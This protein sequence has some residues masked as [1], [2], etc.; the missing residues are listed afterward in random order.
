MSKRSIWTIIIIMTLSLVGVGVIQ[1]F[2]IMKAVAL[3][4]KNFNDKVTIA[5]NNVK[6]KM[7]SDA[8]TLAATQYYEGQGLQAPLDL[9]NES[10]VPGKKVDEQNQSIEQRLKDLEFR[11]ANMKP[12]DLLDNIDKD[13]LDKYLKAE[14]ETK[15]IDLHYEYGVYS[16]KYRSYFIENGSYTATIGDTTKSSNVAAMNPLSKAEFKIALFDDELTSPGH[17]QIYFPG[18]KRFI[19]SSVIGILLSSVVFTGLI[20]FCFA[21]TIYVI[22]HQKKVSEMKTDFINNMTHE[23]KTPIATISLASDSILS[24][25]ILENKEKVIR[26]INIIK[27]ENK[28]MLSQVEKVLQMAQIEKENVELKFNPMNL[29]EVIQDA[30]INAE[31]KVQTKGGHIAINLLAQKPV[32]QADVT[33]ISSIINNLLDNAEKYTPENPQITVSTADVKGGIEFSV[34][35]N[36]IGMSKDALKYIFEKFYRVH[37]GNLHDVKGFGLG[38]SYV[39][40]MVDAHKGKVAVKSE[41]GKGSIFTVFLPEKQNFKF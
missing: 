37:T 2:W 17:L 10:I 34:S 27:Q 25:I 14:L 19:W 13:L 3:D 6:K 33:H 8:E 29:H 30:V 23:F 12:D 41:L 15:D 1:Y 40:A 38:L 26:F 21:Y 18:K 16:N 9:V 36:G 11:N 31:L 28:R 24:P 20:L 39:K 4:E 32:I 5:L 22:F 7:T 35:D